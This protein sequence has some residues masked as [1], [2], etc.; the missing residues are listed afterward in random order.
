[1]PQVIQKREQ[2]LRD[3]EL[4]VD[5]LLSTIAWYPKKEEINRPFRRK[6]HAEKSLSNQGELIY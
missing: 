2:Q 1:M 3:K 4:I 6:R 5:I